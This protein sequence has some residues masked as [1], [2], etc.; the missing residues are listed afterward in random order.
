MFKHSESGHRLLLTNYLN[1]FDHFVGL[2]FKGLSFYIDFVAN[3]IYFLV[4]LLLP[5]LDAKYESIEMG[6]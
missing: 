1:V 4:F 3:N 5:Y 6:K 2:A